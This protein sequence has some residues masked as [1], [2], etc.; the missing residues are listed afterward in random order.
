M[1]PGRLDVQQFSCN[2]ERHCQI[3]F[4]N[5]FW[6]NAGTTPSLS[7]GVLAGICH[8]SESVREVLL[9][10]QDRADVAA[11]CRNDCKGFV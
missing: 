5:R 11:S 1:G 8:L 6:L 3:T 2:V 4:I 10:S 9:G 7:P